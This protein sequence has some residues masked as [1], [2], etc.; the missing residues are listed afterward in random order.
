M[1]G[2]RAWRKSLRDCALQGVVA[3][4]DAGGSGCG[5]C[6]RGSSPRTRA[7]PGPRPVRHYDRIARSLLGET[8][9]MLSREARRGAE[10]ETLRR[11]CRGGAPRAARFAKRA[12]ASQ[13]RGMFGA[14]PGAPLPPDSRGPRN[15]GAPAPFKKQ[16]GQCFAKA[17]CAEEKS[18]NE[19]GAT[20]SP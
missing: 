9:A 11:K 14:L 19:T 15:G 12:P 2:E 4:R 20:L 16:G 10:T 1:A 17:R 5:P 18:R 13:G 7:A 6:G 8:A 3:R